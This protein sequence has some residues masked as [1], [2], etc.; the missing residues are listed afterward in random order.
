MHALSTITSDPM[1][2]G[3]R[4]KCSD[5]ASST[6]QSTDMLSNVRVGEITVRKSKGTASK[7]H[8]E[9]SSVDGGHATEPLELK[10]LSDD[11]EEKAVTAN[12]KQ[13]VNS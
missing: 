10:I 7:K 4:R 13:Q 12:F 2:S 11:N 5:A 9:T 1:S 3:F 6:P 8:S